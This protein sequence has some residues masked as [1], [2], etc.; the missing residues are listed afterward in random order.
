M[1]IVFSDHAKFQLK[2]RKIS[3]RIVRET[4]INP[5]QKV[6]SFKDRKLRQRT[7]GSRILEVVTKTEGSKITVITA[8]FL[9]K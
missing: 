7:V 6:S 8:Y 1:P 9:N 4:I 5:H 2:R 3:Q